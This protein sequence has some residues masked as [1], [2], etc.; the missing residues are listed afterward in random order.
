MTSWIT[1]ELDQLN[2]EQRGLAERLDAVV[3]HVDLPLLDVAASSARLDSRSFHVRFA[4]RT[5]PQLAIDIDA[6]GDG[7]FI[8]SYWEEHESFRKGDAADGRV[9]PFASDDP[10]QAT[11]SLVEA[12]LT[13]RIE[14]HVWRRPLAIRT[15][16]FWINDEGESELFL[17]G[18]TVGPYF[19]WTRTPDVYR[20]DYTG[21]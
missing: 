6:P 17:R 7:E 19:G 16:S 15:R 9:W 11:L 20:F 12:L 10:L 14:L 4:H 5:T 13:G 8:V 21:E 18:G 2:Q 3:T 1:A